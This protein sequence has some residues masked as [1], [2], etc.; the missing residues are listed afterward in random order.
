[1]DQHHLTV[2]HVMNMLSKISWEL[3]N[4]MLTGLEMTVERMYTQESVMN[5]VMANALDHRQLTVFNVFHT[6]SVISTELAFVRTTGQETIAPLGYT[7]EHVLQS[8]TR[9]T[10]V[11][12][13][14]LRTV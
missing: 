6:L 14:R 13:L 1:M 12:D 7:W 4:A 11:Q 10:D 8:V 9:F 2:L 5:F 3:V